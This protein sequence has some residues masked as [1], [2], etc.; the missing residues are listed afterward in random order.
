MKTLRKIVE[1]PWTQGVDEE[2]AYTVDTSTWGGSPSAVSVVLKDSNGDDVSS[3][4]LSGSASVSG[5]IITT[6]VVK[7]LTAD[8]R[9]RLE[10]KFTSSGNILEAYGYIY[11]ET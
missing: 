2:A 6:P 11:G 10:V 3:T 8:S 1:S 7:S 9:Y 5:D 4:N